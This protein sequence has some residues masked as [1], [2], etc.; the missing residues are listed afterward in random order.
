MNV[1]DGVFYNDTS[2]R[3]NT[4]TKLNKRSLKKTTYKRFIVPTGGRGGGRGNASRP[5][6]GEALSVLRHLQ[7]DFLGGSLSE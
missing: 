2:V 1:G 7:S 6:T 3:V 4:S 5:G